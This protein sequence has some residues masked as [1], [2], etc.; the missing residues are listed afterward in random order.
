MYKVWFIFDKKKKIARPAKKARM[1][2]KLELGLNSW[3]AVS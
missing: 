3:V 1:L 2:N